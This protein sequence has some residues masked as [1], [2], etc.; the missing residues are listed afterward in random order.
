MIPV[1]ESQLNNYGR[2]IYWLRYGHSLKKEFTLTA[3]LRPISLTTG[4]LGKIISRRVCLVHIR[5]E[6]L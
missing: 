4:R 1:E 3:V 6:M 2:T 5:L